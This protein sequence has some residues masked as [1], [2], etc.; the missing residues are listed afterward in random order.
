[1]GCYPPRY[2]FDVRFLISFFQYLWQN[3]LLIAIGQ[4]VIAMATGFWFLAK[5]DENRDTE[6]HGRGGLVVKRAVGTVF[7]YHIGSLAFG[8]F[9]LAL[10][11]LIR[12]ILKYFEKQAQAQK[13]KI[14]VLVLK[15]LQ[16]CMWCF[17]QCIKFLNKNAYI[18]IALMGTNFCTSAKNAFYL[19][20]R[21]FIRFGVVAM[22][23]TVIKYLG[24]F[25]I[26]V[27]TVVLGYYIFVAMHPDSPP[28]I[29][30]ALYLFVGY[31]VA[32]LYITVFQLAVDTILQCFII[33][34]ESGNGKDL[35]CSK[36][37]KIVDDNPAPKNQHPPAQE[38][39]DGDYKGGS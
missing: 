10:V 4:C 13:N 39:G 28:I 34:E 21:N 6:G 24:M 17:E 36:L 5:K 18:Q 3:A 15:V 31:V 20:L 9:I 27:A 19:I 37:T 14:M 2:I 38:S 26:T 1:M 12:Y 11:Q 16:C 29:P 30:M 7:R 25:A 22:L 23:G 35:V 8:A 32:K 33:V